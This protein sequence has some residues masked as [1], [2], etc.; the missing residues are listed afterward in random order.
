MKQEEAA[1]LR[2]EVVLLQALAFDLI[3]YAPYRP[4]AGFLMVRCIG[5]LA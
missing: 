5:V 4:I 3:V 2:N 1:L